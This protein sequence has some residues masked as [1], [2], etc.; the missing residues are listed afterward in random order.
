MRRTFVAAAFPALAIAGRN[1]YLDV[2]Q[3]MNAFALPCRQQ[4][5][6]LR[7]LSVGDFNT[8]PV[9]A[10]LLHILQPLIVELESCLVI[11]LADLLLWETFRDP[12]C[13]SR[14]LARPILKSQPPEA[15][16]K[17]SADA[18]CAIGKS[19]PWNLI[20]SPRVDARQSS[21]R[22]PPHMKFQGAW[23]GRQTVSRQQR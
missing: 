21:A 17:G 20:G 7:Q 9:M 14:T 15:A 22:W 19:Q 18:R 2:F 11:A 8:I 16:A 5:W 4:F 13:E 6:W 23:G 10:K 12:G 1:K 3:G